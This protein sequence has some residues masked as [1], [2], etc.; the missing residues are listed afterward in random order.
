MLKGKSI[1]ALGLTAALV[2]STANAVV[3]DLSNSDSGT[4]N[5]ARFDVIFQQPTGTGVIDP[6]LRI[7]G[8]GN[9]GEEQGYNTSGRPTAFDEKT[10]PNF[11]RNITFSDLQSTTTTLNGITYFQILLDVNEPNGSK[12]LITLDSLQLY[13]SAQGSQT[14]SNVSSLGTLRYDLDAGGDNSVIID[15]SRNSGSGSGDIYIYIP[16]ANFAGTSPSDFVYLYAAFGQAE[17]D[18]QGGFEEFAL[19]QNITPIPELSSFF[20]IVGLMVAV[21]ATNVLRRRKMAQQTTV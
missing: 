10:D 6:F 2:A 1:F 11:T 14:T 13:T 17:G 5:G 3:V 9:A 19:V 20:P 12:S 8:T 15:A 18:A 7:Q 21:G 4:I 16:T